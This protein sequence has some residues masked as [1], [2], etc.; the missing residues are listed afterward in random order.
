[1]DQQHLLM[2]ILIL[3]VVILYHI[4]LDNKS[5]LFRSNKNSTNQ[6]RVYNFNKQKLLLDKPLCSHLLF[7][8]GF[9]GYDTTSRIFGVGK[10]SLFQKI[11]N[12]DKD[13]ES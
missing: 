4:E 10:K 11:V 7:I 13:I 9:T 2:K 6:I 12:D 8:H 3:L 5:L 1:M